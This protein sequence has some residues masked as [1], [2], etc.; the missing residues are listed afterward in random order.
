MSRWLSSW[1]FLLGAT[2]CGGADDLVGIPPA[3]A[4][5]EPT[6]PPPALTEPPPAAE[7]VYIHSGE[8]LYRFDPETRQAHLIGPFRAPHGDITRM[9]DIAIDRDGRMFGGETERVS[10]Q[11]HHRVYR[12]DPETGACRF[13]FTHNDALNGLAFLDSGELITAGERISIVDPDSG[14]VLD[15][16][17]DETSPYQTSG[18]IVGLPD[19]YLYWT[20]ED[21]E[22]SKR[23]S[24]QRDAVV[25]LDPNTGDTTLL[26]LAPFKN[27]FGLG[28]AFGTLFGFTSDGHA[29]E[30][31]PED[32]AIVRT[33]ELEGSWWGATTNPVLWNR[34]GR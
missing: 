33:F 5:P 9:V 20:I 17:V 27:I 12:I 15:D 30:I 28:Y 18:D 4:E 23:N 8:A 31:L 21:P 25:R 7:P 22:P 19:G 6:P 13:V 11:S 2:A 14:Q 34:D 32:G 3:P 29:V 24:E 16:V 10:G 26:N 1:F